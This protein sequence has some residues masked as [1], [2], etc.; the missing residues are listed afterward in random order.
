MADFLI[1]VLISLAPSEMTEISEV[2]RPSNGSA[3]DQSNLA[4]MGLIDLQTIHRPD[5]NIFHV[6]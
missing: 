2:K 4:K 1:K 6:F 5:L 3:I